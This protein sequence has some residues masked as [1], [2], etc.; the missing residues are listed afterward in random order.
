MIVYGSCQGQERQIF[1]D[2][3]NDIQI[4]DKKT[5]CSL[6]ILTSIVQQKTKKD[7]GS[8]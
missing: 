6:V 2:W 5:R 4:N 3:L 1:S 8:I 7:N